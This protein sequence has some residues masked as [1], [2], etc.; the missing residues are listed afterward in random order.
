[1]ESQAVFQ[2]KQLKPQFFLL[3]CLPGAVG[4]Y[5]HAEEL[6]GARQAEVGAQRVEAL[7]DLVAGDLDLVDEE[8]AAKVVGGQVV[9]G[10]DEDGDLRGEFGG[11]L[12][13]VPSRNI[14]GIVSL[15]N[16]DV[17]PFCPAAQPIQPYSHL[18]KQN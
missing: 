13:Y 18:P 11:I 16:L 2:A 17:L 15:P 14:Q 5:L 7:D 9:E 4:V 1:M 3:N 8:V 12:P 10:G 6:L